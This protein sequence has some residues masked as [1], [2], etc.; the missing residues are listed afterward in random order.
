MGGDDVDVK[1]ET[2]ERAVHREHLFDIVEVAPLRLHAQEPRRLVGKDQRHPGGRGRAQRP[3]R[4]EI[5]R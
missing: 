1:T 4:R 3:E 2:P 5:G